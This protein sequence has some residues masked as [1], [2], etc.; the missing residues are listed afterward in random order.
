[1]FYFTAAHN[2]LHLGRVSPSGGGGGVMK[3]GFM[4]SGYVLISPIILVK[5]NGITPKL[6]QFMR[7]K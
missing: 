6:L 5:N 4:N 2:Y 3:P 1:M 7:A